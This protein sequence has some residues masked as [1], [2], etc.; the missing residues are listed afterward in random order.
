MSEIDF[1]HQEPFSVPTYN[2]YYHGTSLFRL[3]NE[4][5]TTIRGQLEISQDG[6]NLSGGELTDQQMVENLHR[7]LTH[8]TEEKNSALEM[9]QQTVQELDRLTNEHRVRGLFVCCLN[10]KQC[11]H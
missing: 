3:H 7:Q 9:Y 5:K 10:E 8:L 4:L 2:Q 11:L 1:L 6:F